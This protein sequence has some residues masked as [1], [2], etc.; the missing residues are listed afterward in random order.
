MRRQMVTN[1]QTRQFAEE[2]FNFHASEI[3]KRC[4][5]WRAVLHIGRCQDRFFE[6]GLA[7]SDAET[8]ESRMLSIEFHKNAITEPNEWTAHWEMT[9]TG[10]KHRSRH[11]CAGS[12]ASYQ[13]AEIVDCA[14]NRANCTPTNDVLLSYS[15]SGE[16]DA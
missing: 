8:L 15:M 9:Q 5:S 3:E 4:G 14:C 10:T 6:V 11:S 7:L 16:F 13:I 12:A 1:E 2:L